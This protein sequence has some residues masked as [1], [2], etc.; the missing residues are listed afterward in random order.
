MPF[1]EVDRVIYRTNPLD[2]V[3][4]Q[5]R[6]PP[7]LKIDTEI[8][9]Q[10]QDKLRSEYPN[11]SE[12]KEV[13]FNIQMGMQNKIPSEE[14]KQLSGSSESKNYEFSSENN[15]WK[16]NLTRSFL[17]L[18]TNHYTRWDEFRERLQIAIKTFVD[19]YQPLAFSRIGLRYID[20][21]MRSKL[22]LAEEGWDKLIQPYL[23]G[24]MALDDIKDEILQYDSTFLINLE[25]GE[26]KVRVATSTVKQ[27]SSGE[28]CY[29]IDSDFFNAK[30]TKHE[31]VMKK[32]DFFNVR[33]ARLFR[34]C[35]TEK[36]HSSMEPTKI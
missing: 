1:P 35:I 33:A 20:I 11:L 34:W 3:I 26:S 29:M 31:E 5:L 32:L 8:P 4:C 25:D 36:L 23:L 17:S 27:A 10:F 13:L 21:I 19:I 2:R 30:K 7:I 18:S 12:S 14:F 9:S 28:T 16:I 15:Q 24:I 6:F 22:K